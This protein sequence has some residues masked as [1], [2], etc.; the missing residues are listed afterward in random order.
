[1]NK[2]ILF[3]FTAN[4]YNVVNEM[5]WRIADYFEQ[6][7]GCVV[8]RYWLKDYERVKNLDWD[9]VFSA[10]AI[11]FSRLKEPDDRIHI[12]WLVDHPRYVIARFVDYP[13]MDK[14]YIGCVDRTHMDYLTAYYGISN[15]FFAPH[16]GWKASNTIPYEKRSCDIFFPASYV[17]FEEDVARRYEGLTGALKV[18]VD[19]TIAFLLEHTQ[20]SLEKGVQ[21]VLRQFGEPDYMELSKICMEVAGEYIDFYLRTTMRERVLREL[22][23]KG[24]TVTVCG[25][26]WTHF[27]QRKDETGELVILG[28]EL[29]YTQVFHQMA[30]SRIILNVMPWFKDGSHERVVMAAM[31]GAIAATDNSAYISKIWGDGR[32]VIYD[33]NEPERLAGRIKELL[34]CQ[35]EAMAVAQAGQ[36]AAEKYATVRNWGTYLKQILGESGMEF[37]KR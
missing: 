36:K 27:L 1:M 3:V 13:Q 8:G 18:I 15:T 2:K 19:K 4:Q 16:F 26:N 10:Q 30:D 23:R 34:L 35:D 17:R 6:S 22:L 28:E 31:N 7:C 25:K 24:L 33:L 11:E 32:A 20:Y 9:M 5:V 37:Q 21:M 29:T 12:I 14:I